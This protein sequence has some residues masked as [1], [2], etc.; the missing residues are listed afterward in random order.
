MA[1]VPAAGSW[2]A[3]SWTGPLVSNSRRKERKPAA[4][5]VQLLREEKERISN[6]NPTTPRGLPPRAR[7]AR[8]WA[9][10]NTCKREERLLGATREVIEQLLVLLQRRLVL[11]L[12]RCVQLTQRRQKVRRPGVQLPLGR[13]QF[14][15]PAATVQLPAVQLP[16][17][18]T[19]PVLP[20]GM[21]LRLACGW[22][23]AVGLH[24]H[25]CVRSARASCTVRAAVGHRPLAES[26]TQR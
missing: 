18:G 22:P 2:T 13:K 10:R 25:Q 23:A 8:A 9:L 24:F 11:L 14:F 26:A 12:L 6:K 21:A 16:A 17:A 19:V 15:G 1:T 20:T 5:I 4:A 3:G 7:A